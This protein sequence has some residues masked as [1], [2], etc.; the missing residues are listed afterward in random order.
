MTSLNSGKGAKGD[1]A[2]VLYKD[3]QTRNTTPIIQ[4][5]QRVTTAQL[6][7][8]FSPQYRAN[9]RNDYYGSYHPVYSTYYHPQ[10]SYG[11]WDAI[12][13]ASIMDNV[14]DRQMY[15]HHQN[16]TA[17]QSW[18]TDANAACAAGD[19]DV[20]DKL[21]DLDK[22]MSEYKTKGVKQ[23]P[24]YITP[25]VDP[26]VYE[27]NKIDPKSLP[28]LK[29]CTG[30]IGS[31]YNRF[32][33]LLST[34][35]KLRVTTVQSNGSVDNL[36]KMASGA[37]DLGFV[38]D[39]LLQTPNL[40]KVVTVNQLEVGLLICPKESGIKTANDLTS[41]NTIYI[42]SDQTGSQFTFDQI[43]SKVSGLSKAQVNET[44]S[45]MAAVGTIKN[46]KTDCLFAVSSAE[47]PGFMELDK[48]G[49]FQGVMISSVP[50]YKPVIVDVTHYKNLTQKD[51]VHR[52][53]FLWLSSTGGTD[54][55]GVSTSLVTSQSWIDQNK[56][57]FDLLL[58]ERVNLS[59]SLQ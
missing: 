10:P 43:K 57:L 20:C 14:G 58:L 26:D 8:T 49:K 32:A 15:Y 50:G 4:P 13:F 37:C 21:A 56:Q 28:E 59:S 23:N 19:K 6:N 40:S 12:M 42:G 22:E 52:T 11:M 25:G 47:Y 36:T 54:T 2:G 55:I 38:Q 48:S 5:G 30:A 16:D 24:S 7:Q 1:A 27:S 51:F 17:F 39:D 53:G 44:Q 35:T 34:I 18:R 31:D 3:F 46:S 33:A 29:I 9:R 41:K 45:A